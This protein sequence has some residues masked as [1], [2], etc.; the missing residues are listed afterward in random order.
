M[1]KKLTYILICC[2]IALEFLAL[3]GCT[4]TDLKPYEKN[5]SYKSNYEVFEGEIADYLDYNYQ[6]RS[7]YI[8][9]LKVF[10][11]FGTSNEGSVSIYTDENALTF[12]ITKSTGSVT[13]TL[14]GPLVYFKMN[15]D[16]N[17]IIEKKFKPA[18]NY[19]ELGMVKFIE[20]SEEVIELTDERM[21]EIGNYLK[22]LIIEIEAN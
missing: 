13:G 11:E 15:L 16:T 1:T 21:V 22:E 6:D 12:T 8:A 20:H 4:E 5:V 14:D 9:G 19:K 2:V 17:E 10:E 18:P 7:M 3:S